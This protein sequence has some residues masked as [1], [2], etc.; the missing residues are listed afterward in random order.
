MAVWG[1]GAYFP[2]REG[3]ITKQCLKE[4]VAVIGFSKE[5]KPKYF[6]M[7]QSIEVGDLIF[8]K[9]RFMLNQP[10]RIKA[11]GVVKSSGI[12]TIPNVYNAK[13]IKVRWI[14]DFSDAPMQ[15]EKGREQDGD[16]RTI[17]QEKNETVIKQIIEML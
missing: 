7:L 1:I 13:G 8:I 9:S 15:I 6:E 10:L 5:E 4:E 14:K 11:V 16:T 12:E 2:E 3:D 17:Y